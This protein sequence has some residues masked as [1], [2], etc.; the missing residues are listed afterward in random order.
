MDSSKYQTLLLKKNLLFS[1][2]FEIKEE[3]DENNENE[4]NEDL[5]KI[6]DNKSKGNSN[7]DNDKN[8]EFEKIVDILV[9]SGKEKT[10]VSFYEN[11]TIQELVEYL[12]DN[13]F[14]SQEKNDFKI[15]YGLEELKP[16]DSRLISE[17]ISDNEE[18]QI[19]II[20]KNEEKKKDYIP[21]KKIEK[22]YVSLENIPSFMD[23]SDQINIFIN[24]H[25]KEEVKYDI[26]YRNNCCNIMFLAP[27]ISFSFVTFMTNLKFTNKYYR[28]IIIKIKYN[29][30][31]NNNYHLNQNLLNLN[32]SSNLLLKT[33]N[34]KNMNKINSKNIFNHKKINYSSR[35][36]N[37]FL[38][39]T[40]PNKIDDY[41]NERYKSINEST[42]YEQENILNKL[43][44]QRSKKKWITYK[45]FF[46]GANTKSFNRFIN[47]YKDKIRLASVDNNNNKKIFLNVNNI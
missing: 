5:P 27:E 42:P 6:K 37:H 20:I 4:S 15:I 26:K 47:P 22:I 21:N 1:K 2:V 36:Y 28:K 10:T 35:S 29:N 12:Y 30:I 44:K 41:F 24:K 9:Y 38:L 18:K 23:L 39:N 33:I 32:N 45:G 34:N 25:Q 3:N 8:I 31:K 17:I 40:E 46:N 16:N 43:E 13:N 19:R 11:K 7:Y 14:L